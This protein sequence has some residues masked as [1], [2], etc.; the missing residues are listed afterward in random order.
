MIQAGSVKISIDFDLSTFPDVDAKAAV[1]KI[2]FLGGVTGD[3]DGNKFNLW[4]RLNINRRKISTNFRNLESAEGQGIQ[5]IP[6][7]ILGLTE[8][9][10]LPVFN[11]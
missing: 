5:A 8:T 11:V 4:I 3:R 9:S 6:A 1:K 10:F 7:A 2:N